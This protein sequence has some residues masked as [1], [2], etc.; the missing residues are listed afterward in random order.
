MCRAASPAVGSF[1]GVDSFVDSVVDPVGA[2][3]ALLA[4]STLTLASAGSEVAASILGTMA[5]AVAC[6]S[7][8]NV[9]VSSEDV[10][11]KLEIVEKRIQY[12]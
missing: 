3:D 1:F 12:A 4:Y 7:E 9:P 10:M 11:K 2:G 6:E 5:A 8:G